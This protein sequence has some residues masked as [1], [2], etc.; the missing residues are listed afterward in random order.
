[1]VLGLPTIAF[2]LLIAQVPLPGLKLALG[3]GVVLMVLGAVTAAAGFRYVFTPA[4]VEVRTL[5]FRLRSIAAH[6]IT[7]YAVDRWNA[8]G[9]Y[10]IRG[11]GEKRAYVWGNRGVRI[12]TSEGEVFLGHN[13]PEKIVRDLDLVKQNPA[14]RESNSDF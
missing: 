3:L 11:I 14:M 10:G 9:G 12:K 8:L 4:G 13:D 1:M 6:D 2:V 5:D 7:S